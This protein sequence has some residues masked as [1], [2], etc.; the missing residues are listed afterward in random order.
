[1]T[2]EISG[3]LVDFRGRISSD[4]RQVLEAISRSNGKDMA[5]IVR[6]VL[7]DWALNEI[8]RASLICRMT[9]GKGVDQD[10]KGTK[11]TV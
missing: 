11:G 8:H 7:H 6:D 3:E 2:Q 5:E 10:C 1:M 4:T 9:R